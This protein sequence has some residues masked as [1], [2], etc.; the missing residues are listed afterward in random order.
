MKS[1]PTSL[2]QREELPLLGYIFPAAQ[3]GK[4]GTC[5]REAPPCG[6]KAGARISND[7][8]NSTLRPLI[9]TQ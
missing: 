7:D 2:S 5:L 3:A 6:T 4:R 8:V 1:L 9:I